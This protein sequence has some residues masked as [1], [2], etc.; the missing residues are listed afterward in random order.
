MKLERKEKENIR[1]KEGTMVKTEFKV[2]IRCSS[3]EK[4]IRWETQIRED[5][6]KHKS[7]DEECRRCTAAGGS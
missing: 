4:G 5:A 2:R 3:C 6:D 1:I 7:Q